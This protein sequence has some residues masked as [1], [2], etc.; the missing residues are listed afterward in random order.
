M[1]EVA[2]QTYG[3][4][5]LEE[6]GRNLDALMAKAVYRSAA[7]LQKLRSL[8]TQDGSVDYVCDVVGE[9]GAPPVCWPTRRSSP[10]LRGNGSSIQ[11]SWTFPKTSL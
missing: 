5:D 6:A 2:L 9:D 1:N 4:R 8:R 11:P 3:V 10:P 7:D